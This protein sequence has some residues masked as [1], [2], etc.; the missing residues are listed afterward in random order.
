MSSIRHV[1]REAGV[2]IATVSR[3]L[4]GNQSVKSDLRTKVLRAADNCDYRPTVGKRSAGCIAMVYTGPFCVGSPYDSACLE[5]IVN[6][7]RMTKYDLITLDIHR[8]RKREESVAQYFSRKGV[9][10]A[11]VRST[12]EERWL[13]REMAGEN[14][15]IVVLGDH[16]DCPGLSFCYSDSRNASREAIE[17]LI[18]LGHKSIAFAVCDRDDGDHLDRFEAYREVLEESGLYREDL[19]HRVPPSRM[20][21]VPLI[22]RIMS[23]ED[24]PTAAFIADPLIAVGALNE[25]HK[26]GVSIPGDLSLVAVDDTDLRSMVYP[27]LTAVCQDSQLIGHEAFQTVCQLVTG[28]LDPETPKRHEAW[29]EIHDTTGPVP[30][31]VNRF[32]PG[33]RK[34]G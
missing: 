9:A 34:N 20:D 27:R 32:L 23:R 14:V 19:V 6:A 5:G 10:G 7:M 4:N 2:S 13:L 30:E 11:I 18:S 15:P 28:K 33:S 8:D 22:R 16:F 26:M 29:F 3:V 17:H 21:G 25:A 24:R 31:H 1:A 12:L